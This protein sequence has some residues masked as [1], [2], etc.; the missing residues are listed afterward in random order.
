MLV[1][2]SSDGDVAV[3]AGDRWS[4]DDPVDDP[5]LITSRLTV[6]DLVGL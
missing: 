5:Q 1:L 6:R 4:G 3:S 2:E